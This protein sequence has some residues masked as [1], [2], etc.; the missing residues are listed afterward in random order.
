[1]PNSENNCAAFSAYPPIARLAMAKQILHHMKRILDLGTDTGFGLLQPFLRLA[2]RWFVQGTT[3][4]G[5]HRNMPGNRRFQMLAAL[6]DI[7]ISRIPKRHSFVA[8][9]QG[10]R[11]A[12]VA[13]MP[14]CA[15]TVC[16]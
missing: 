1:M 5:T 10:L 11:L 4:T 9:Q 15:M 7:L 12:D 3:F 13:D 6:L 16:T 2:F 8:M 14:R